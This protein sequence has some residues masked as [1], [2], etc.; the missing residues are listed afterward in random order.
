MGCSRLPIQ[1]RSPVAAFPSLP[2][3]PRVHRAQLDHPQQVAQRFRKSH[4]F[5]GPFMC[6][7]AARLEGVW[8]GAGG[9]NELLRKYAPETPTNMQV[10]LACQ[11]PAVAVH[12]RS[13]VQGEALTLKSITPRCNI[14]L[15]FYVFL[16]SAMRSMPSS[17]PSSSASFSVL[18]VLSLCS[19]RP[20]APLSLL[21]LLLAVLV[22]AQEKM[23]ASLGP[24]PT[25]PTP[26]PCP[27]PPPPNRLVLFAP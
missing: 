17:S 27:P 20:L 22:L 5:M 1:R 16:K 18:V 9:Q 21:L 13:G 24:S 2:P 11:C 7:C 12:S 26:L 10:V 15:Q 3:P 25:P 23:G 8:V 4:D 19:T 6:V 14:K